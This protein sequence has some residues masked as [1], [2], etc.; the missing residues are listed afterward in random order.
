NH[1]YKRLG[2]DEIRLIKL[3]PSPDPDAD[4]LCSL[5]HV[6]LTQPYGPYEAVSYAWGTKEDPEKL[7][8][9]AIT[10]NLDSALRRFRRSNAIR[11]LWADAVCLDQESTEEKFYQI[12]NIQEIY[13]K[14]SNVLIWLGGAG[15]EG[16][17]CLEFF[18]RLSKKT[19][20]RQVELLSP[21]NLA[22]MIDDSLDETFQHRRLDALERFFHP[23]NRPW[24]LRRWVIQ[25]V[26]ASRDA[27]VYCG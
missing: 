17:I 25:E 8:Y 1:E 4:L 24:F 13:T 26:G 3:Y 18:D 22:R 16:R 14:A 23:V 9:I 2:K 5:F 6:D 12:P 27:L 21:Q 11:L 19:V 20:R 7:Y 15:E 10:A